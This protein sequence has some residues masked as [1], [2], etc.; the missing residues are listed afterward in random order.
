MVRRAGGIVLKPM[1]TLNTLG[2]LPTGVYIC[3]IQ[4]S[5]GDL[6]TMYAGIGLGEAIICRKIICRQTIITTQLVAYDKM[7]ILLD[8]ILCFKDPG[9]KV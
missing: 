5:F 7:K 2:T 3:R 6:Q 8:I 4:D 9:Q 1:A